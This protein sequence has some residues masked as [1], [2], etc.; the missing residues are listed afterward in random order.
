MSDVAYIANIRIE[1][2]RGPLRHAYLP[3]VSEPV[4]FGV[5]SAIAEHYRV[6]M[7]EHDPN[8]TTIDYLIS[9]TGG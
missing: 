5:H 8:A 7:T 4:K 2:I 1:R 9:A 6:D 3:E